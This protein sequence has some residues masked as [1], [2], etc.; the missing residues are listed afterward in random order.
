MALRVAAVA[1]EVDHAI[2]DDPVVV[3]VGLPAERGRVDR[4]QVVVEQASSCICSEAQSKPSTRGEANEALL[5]LEPGG[6]HEVFQVVFE[7]AD[8][9]DMSFDARGA[10]PP[11]V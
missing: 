8:I 4:V 7:L 9:V 2:D 10:V 1:V 6:L 11:D 3:E 5:S